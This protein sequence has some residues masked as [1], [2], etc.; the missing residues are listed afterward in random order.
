MQPSNNGDGNNNSGSR[1]VGRLSATALALLFAAETTLFYWTFIRHVAPFYPINFDQTSY[2][3]DTYRIF[4]NG[5]SGVVGE[6]VEGAHAA[7]VTFTA[8]GAVLG[9]LFGPSRPVIISLNL[10]YFLILQLVQ[11][12]VV[13]ARTRSLEL[14]WLSLALL[15]SCKT[16]FNA[17]GGIY[18][19][20]IDFSALCLYGIW[21]CTILWSDTFR[22]TTRSFIAAAVAIILISLRYFTVL[23]VAANLAALLLLFLWSA[24][25]TNLDVVDRH[26]A[27]IR[28][29][30]IVA[31]SLLI[32][33]IIGPLLLISRQQI[34]AYYGVGHVL[35]EEKYIRAHELGLFTAR[36][37]IFF[38]PKSIVIDHVGW[39]TIALTVFA[40]VLATGPAR[41][42]IA[43]TMLARRLHDYRI[44]LAATSAAC[45]FPL[46]ALTPD[47][48]KSAVV[49]GIVVGP[50]ILFVTFLCAVV[51]CPASAATIDVNSKPAKTATV[52]VKKFSA[53]VQQL[54]TL[55]TIAIGVSI[56]ANRALTPPDTRPVS[57]LRRVT[58]VNEVIARYLI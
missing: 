46:L 39:L 23:Y 4:A 21:I 19:Y 30:N 18:D 25:K 47:I 3:L 53:P 24:L 58:E 10:G 16:I 57:D 17:A 26:L 37:H 36:D 6:F 14:A 35:G 22:Y 50:I 7:G 9:L 52:A 20:R 48:A 8:Q 32:A 45:I 11:F 49:G 31:A 42:W 1:S 51:W 28:A 33:A 15:I 38:Y 2:Y 13:L 41:F 40:F 54:G 12:K 5:W 27:S 56:F 29:R 43:R 34:F 44:D 55:I